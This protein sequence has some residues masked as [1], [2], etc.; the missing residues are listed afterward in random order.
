MP[1]FD[2]G[3]LEPGIVAKLRAV[4]ASQGVAT[5]DV[6]GPK[7]ASAD[8]ILVTF[9]WMARAACMRHGDAS[10]ESEQLQHSVFEGEEPGRDLRERGWWEQTHSL[11][12]TDRCTNSSQTESEY[13]WA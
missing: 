8:A 12:F 9:G 5:I 6:G 11:I 1:K 2:A 7:D 3:Q 4:L 10:T 13:F